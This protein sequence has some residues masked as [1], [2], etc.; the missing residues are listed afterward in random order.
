MILRRPILLLPAALAL[1]SCGPPARA[2]EPP[3]AA[4]VVVAPVGPLAVLAGP[5]PP[6]PPPPGLRYTGCF[7]RRLIEPR[8]SLSAGVFADVNRD[9]HRDLIV[10]QHPS[11]G[12]AENLLVV[13]AADGAGGFAKLREEAVPD[14][15]LGL[16]GGDFN[17]DGALDLVADDYD[18]GVVD[19]RL[20]DPKRGWFVKG[21]T[22]P[23]GPKPGLVG[24][25]DINGD[26]HLDLAVPH[27]QAVR[28]W[29]GNGKGVFRPG[30][31][32]PT[33]K[34]PSRPIFADLNGDGR[35]DLAVASND[36]H[37]LSV[38]LQGPQ[39]RL[40]PDDRYPCGKGGAPLAVA[41]VDGDGQPDL[42]MGNVNS[43]TTCVFRNDGNG[44][45]SLLTEL[46]AGAWAVGAHDFHGDGRATI[47]IASSLRGRR[48]EPFA[49]WGRLSLWSGG[50]QGWSRRVELST[51]APAGRLWVED[52]D[53]DGLLD[54]V[55]IS[56]RGVAVFSGR[57]CE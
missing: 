18:R 13:L 31:R 9:G 48:I 33:G 35:Q 15:W 3:R 4:K 17:E 45:L 55:T 36:S 1:A 32:L 46:P 40:G 23:A 2:P 57:R 14:G 29:L 24:S 28:L 47:L 37:F 19:L 52:T 22:V 16:E 44:K 54:I 39:G 50:E 27:A 49:D 56:Q 8:M 21:R 12:P 43:H 42:T 34:Y 5:E 41:D 20:G 51:P 26:G 38:F 6:A 10:L 53:G 25:G 30:Q 11:D 7:A